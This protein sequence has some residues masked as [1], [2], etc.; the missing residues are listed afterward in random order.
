[1]KDAWYL[2]ECRRST[3][4]C[5]RT[6]SIPIMSSEANSALRLIHLFHECGAHLQ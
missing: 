3:S 1:M 2:K 4:S 5:S 6:T